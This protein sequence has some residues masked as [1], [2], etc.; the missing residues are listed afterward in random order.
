MLGTLAAG[1]L[2]L[3]PHT[4]MVPV[5]LSSTANLL[6]AMNTAEEPSPRFASCTA[7]HSTAA[8]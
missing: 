7:Q 5:A 2:L 1:K 4:W 6:R 8:T 3:L